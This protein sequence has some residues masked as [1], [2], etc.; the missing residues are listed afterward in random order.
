MENVNPNVS[1]ITLN[2]V[3]LNILIKRQEIGRVN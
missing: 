2:V 3:C 1:V